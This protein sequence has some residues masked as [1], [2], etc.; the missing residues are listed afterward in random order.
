MTHSFVT[1]VKLVRKSIEGTA[2]VIRSIAL[3]AYHDDILFLASGLAFNGILTMIPIMLLAASFIG[4]ALNSSVEGVQQLNDVLDAMFPPQP[5]AQNIRSSILDVIQGIVTYRTSLGLFGVGV[6]IWT[7]T[8]LFDALRSALH[9]V[10]ELKR[11]RSFFVSFLH[12]VGFVF[13]AVVLFIASNMVVW[14][15]SVAQEYLTEIPA[16]QSLSLPQFNRVVPTLIVTALTGGMFYMI[17]RYL[18]DTKPPRSAAVIS[19]VTT[20]VL[21]VASGRVFAL[22]LANFS[23]IGKI[24]GPYAFLLVLLFWI[25]YSSIVFVLGG[26]VGQVYWERLKLKENSPGMQPA[27]AGPRDIGKATPAGHR[28]R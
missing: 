16:L 21:W 8:S 23:A 12:D 7:A 3:K 2:A 10:Y 14:V 28:S 15:F 20:T 1:V 9:R 13:L 27:V 6:L 22:Y 11:T 4:S 26:I 18:T 19:T 24:Y 25:Y 17:Y 5:F